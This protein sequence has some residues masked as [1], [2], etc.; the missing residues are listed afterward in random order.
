MTRRIH[1]VPARAEAAKAAVL[2]SPKTPK[3]VI[4]A[5]LG[6]SVGQLK[7]YISGRFKPYPSPYWARTF[8]ACAANLAFNQLPQAVRELR[9]LALEIENHER[10]NLPN[11]SKNYSGSIHKSL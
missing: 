9:I 3:K 2:A 6:I 5:A 7:F 4:A 10:W 1:E 8:Y 11:A